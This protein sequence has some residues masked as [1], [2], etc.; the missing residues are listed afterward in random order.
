[1]ACCR[2]RTQL[3]LKYLER[4]GV[5]ALVFQVSLRMHHTLYAVMSSSVM[6]MSNPTTGR[7]VS[8]VCSMRTLDCRAVYPIVSV[9]CSFADTCFSVLWFTIF[10]LRLVACAGD[11]EFEAKLLHGG[12]SSRVCLVC[13]HINC[14]QATLR[15]VSCWRL[16]MCQAQLAV[17]GMYATVV[18][19]I[20]ACLHKRASF[21]GR[22]IAE[23]DGAWLFNTFHHKPGT[24]LVPLLAEGDILTVQAR[25]R[26]LPGGFSLL[27]CR[28]CVEFGLLACRCVA[29]AK[30]AT[31]AASVCSA[32]AKRARRS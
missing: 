11:F 20:S 27:P 23:S 7:S 1:M 4:G 14:R 5:C 15:L 32:T 13:D 29:H 17:A 31:V 16:S 10:E 21:S 3:S 30:A 26:G 19:F 2:T 24:H 25:A 12:A 9:H 6:C 22:R 18:A 8:L 28:F